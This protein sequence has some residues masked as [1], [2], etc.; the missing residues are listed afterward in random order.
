MELTFAWLGLVRLH[1]DV[2]RFPV[3]STPRRYVAS[4]R[5]VLQAQPDRPDGEVVLV[6]A[7][8]GANKIISLGD[9]KTNAKSALQEF[10]RAVVRDKEPNVFGVRFKDT[11]IP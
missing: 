1:D 4:V 10:R 9:K 6:R 5:P 11:K 3:P 8:E 2:N 7:F